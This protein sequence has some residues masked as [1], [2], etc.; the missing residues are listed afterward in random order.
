MILI[1]DHC[2]AKDDRESC[3]QF[4][5]AAHNE[6]SQVLGQG[7]LVIEIGPHLIAE[8]DA[9]HL[10]QAATC[11][12]GEIGV[13]LDTVD[14]DNAGRR[15]G[16]PVHEQWQTFCYANSNDIHGGANRG[17][18]SLL[19]DSTLGKH[20]Q[21]TFSASPAVR[22][23]GR[24][25]ERPTTRSWSLPITSPTISLRRSMPRLPTATATSAPGVNLTLSHRR[26]H[27]LSNV[28]ATSIA[29]GTVRRCCTNLNPGSFRCSTRRPC[30]TGGTVTCP[31]PLRGRIDAVVSLRDHPH[32]DLARP[33]HAYY[34]NR[35]DVRRVA[36]PRD[37]ADAA[38][39]RALKC[40]NLVQDVTHRHA[41]AAVRYEEPD[42]RWQ[43]RITPP[44]LGAAGHHD[45]SGLGHRPARLTEPERRLARVHG[46]LVGDA[47]PLES[48]R[49]C[50]AAPGA[51]GGKDL[52]RTFGIGA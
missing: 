18:N 17:T 14:K 28:P 10:Q 12:T 39:E 37:E 32:V 2:G 49:T 11:R 51:L 26:R 8:P 52:K 19:R 30:T 9:K 22:A 42:G 31:A 48:R 44:H 24:H 13:R 23:H 34:V 36:W 41:D 38:G 6:V 16:E 40:G 46:P 5:S 47:R 3:Q 15:L 27:S 21:L 43:Q 29:G 20:A 35:G 33:V 1:L 4:V 25:D 50:D 45:R 7:R